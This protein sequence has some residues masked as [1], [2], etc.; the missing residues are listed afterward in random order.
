MHPLCARCASKGLVAVAKIADHDPPHR[1]NWNQFWIGPLQS[2]C[3][4]C[5]ESGKKFEEQRGFR[6]DIGADGWPLD[7]KHP[8]YGKQ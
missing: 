8:T 7:P 1:G 6:N 5:H 4:N 2:L 3:R